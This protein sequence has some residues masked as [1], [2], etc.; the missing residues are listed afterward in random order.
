ML[1]CNNT[2]NSRGFLMF[3]GG[4]R[5]AGWAGR[6]TAAY[7]RAMTDADDLAQRYLTLW[8]QY[9][10]AL[11]ADPRAMETLKRWI[12]FTG[13]F[14][15]P[16]PGDKAAGEAPFP[17]W[18]PFFGPFGFPSAPPGAAGASAAGSDA[19]AA[20]AQRVD[21]LERR[22]AA[23]ERKPKPARSGRGGRGGG[24]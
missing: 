20:L 24:R 11:L 16:A 21:E 12:A 15:Y 2:A 3:R 18:P 17:T 8:T 22:L 5:A 23:L 9:L 10:A 19:I 6:L 14:S 7:N 1:P 13:Q 4:R